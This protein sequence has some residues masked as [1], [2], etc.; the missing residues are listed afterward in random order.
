[1]LDG[2]DVRLPV[3]PLLNAAV[4]GRGC[5]WTLLQMNETAGALALGALLRPIM[6]LGACLRRPASTLHPTRLLGRMHLA[7]SAGFVRQG[8]AL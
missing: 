3:A 4:A 2:L 7:Q 5:C 6:L 1:M 8:S